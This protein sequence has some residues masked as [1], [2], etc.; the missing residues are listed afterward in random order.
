MTSAHDAPQDEHD[1]QDVLCGRSAEE[2][3]K[4]D[5]QTVARTT[6]D[7]RPEQALTSALALGASLLALWAADGVIANG[8]TQL[9]SALLL[10]VAT[11]VLLRLPA[12]S[13]VRGRSTESLDLSDA[14]V[15]PAALLLPAREAVLVLVLASLLCESTHARA[16]IKRVFNTSLCVLSGG[17]V[18]AAVAVASPPAADDTPWQAAALGLA[19]SWAFSAVVLCLLFA[20]INRVSLA[21]ELRRSAL[22]GEFLV[23]AVALTVGV[24][25][26]ELVPDHP[27][28]LLGFVSLAALLLLSV[29]DAQAFGRD[30]ERLRLLLDLSRRI[31]EADDTRSRDAVLLDAAHRLLP[32]HAFALV[33]TPPGSA[34]TPARLALSKVGDRW[35][36]AT[37]LRHSDPWTHQD[38]YCLDTL[39]DAA[40]RALRL[41]ERQ[42]SLADE[43]LVDPLTGLANRRRISEE[44]DRPGPSA[45]ALLLLDLNGFKAVNDRRGHHVGDVV[46]QVSAER[47]RTAVGEGRLV[48]RLG[49]DEFVVVLRDDAARDVGRVV[50]DIRLA[51]AAPV[52]HA[53]GRVTVGVSIGA[54]STQTD[55]VTAHDL[56]ALADARM[57]QDKAAQRGARAAQ[58]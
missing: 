3:R 55:G 56:L 35:L 8:W 12:V 1:R 49:G 36:A 26:A 46:L 19:L 48:A 50:E 17:L 7:W 30:R 18:I 15:V 33:H 10:T 5:V 37:P 40:A 20:M 57:Y 54:A 44:L 27:A 38:Q 2:Q 31:G 41:A 4:A 9:Q 16:P 58:D 6:G 14:C 32:W 43:A 22:R 45:T 21:Q 25:A 42:Q 24:A 11:A 47:L 28:A 39:A 34:C 23:L 13:V 29:R 53:Q 52:E 51:F